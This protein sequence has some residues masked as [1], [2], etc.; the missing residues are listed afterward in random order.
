MWAPP[1]TSTEPCSAASG[2]AGG[3]GSSCHRG[4]AYAVAASIATSNHTRIIPRSYDIDTC[5]SVFDRL[6]QIRGVTWTWNEQAS[7]AGKEPGAADAGVLAQ[8]VEAVYPEL[9]TTG[10]EGF[11]QE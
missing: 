9:V 11:K 6:A 2:M 8:D 7:V 10:P 3:M 5:M 4:L 1:L